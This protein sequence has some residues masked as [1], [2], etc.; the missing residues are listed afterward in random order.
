MSMQLNRRTFLRASGAMVALPM[1]ESMAR[2]EAR[3]GA[4]QRMVLIGTTMGLLSQY[5]FPEKAGRDYALTPYL[6]L[7]QDHRGDFTVFSGVSHPYV[8]GGH[9]GEKSFLTAAPHPGA[10]AFRN[11]ISVDQV[12]AERIGA[13]TRF[14]S[15]VLSLIHT[16]GAS[17][18]RTGVMI[19]PERNPAAL[20]RRLFVQGSPAEVDRSIERLRQG[21]SL[22]DVVNDRARALERDLGRADRERL[23][24][25]LASVRDLEA[26]LHAAEAWEKKPRPAPGAP[27]PRENKD[28]NDVAGQLRLM[29][30]VI[31]LALETD[32]TRVISFF[33]EP[34]STAPTLPGVSQ[35]IHSLTHLP[36][37]EGFAQ[38]KL[39]EESM[40]RELSTFLGDLKSVR[41][42]GTT[43][44][45]RT[46]VLFGS[47]LGNGAS[48]SNSNLP[49]IL[50]GGGF[51]HG[52]HLAFDRHRNY[53]LPNLFVSL[54][55]RLGLEIDRFAS[56]TG[57]M[58]GLEL[59]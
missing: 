14:P 40:L 15:L 59:A 46:S 52:Q 18:T 58:R 27:P 36:N 29:L 45:S 47:S 3:P 20:Y 31:R 5:F 26:E 56:S 50:A 25:Y 19:P 38:L 6:E 10:G 39:F 17:F 53:P 48:H 32:S 4:P 54:L 16:K 51:R 13:K 22:L 41:E 43:L 21:R 55:Q 9:A 23:G 34:A 24:Q 28:K 11:S 7:L 30:G 57:T 44:L 33:I 37:P 35:D 42:E 1:L 8:D 2:G 49:V 12:A